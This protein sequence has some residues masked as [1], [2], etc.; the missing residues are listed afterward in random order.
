MLLSSEQ[1]SCTILGKLLAQGDRKKLL[2]A[3][4]SREVLHVAKDPQRAGHAAVTPASV[5]AEFTFP[6]NLLR[7]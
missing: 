3:T 5:Y 6:N 4:V 1:H 7:L 2:Q